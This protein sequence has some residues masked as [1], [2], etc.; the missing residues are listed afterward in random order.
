[1]AITRQELDGSPEISFEGTAIKVTC[2]YMI[3]WSSVL[4]F[5]L[6]ILADGGEDSYHVPDMRV[7]ARRIP[8]VEG[9][10]HIDRGAPPPSGSAE[11]ECAIVTV[12]YANY[13]ADSRDRQVDEVTKETFSEQ[14]LPTTE[15]LTVA[16]EDANQ[17]ALFSWTGVGGAPISS[18]QA[19]GMLV[20]SFDYLLTYFDKRDFDDRILTEYPGTVNMY[21]L[22]TRWGLWF[23]PETLLFHLPS[24]ERG[25]TATGTEG[26]RITYQ[27][28]Y[29]KDTWNKF[30]NPK[31]NAWLPLWN[32]S[33]GVVQQFYKP[34]L[35]RH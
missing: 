34:M 19:P 25:F 8:R 29:R 9:F 4:S 6:E 22:S 28:S 15:F 18:D 7:V 32:I 20:K 16:T 31:E 1:M 30:Y 17:Q 11:Y 35:W 24:L 14:I 27:Y 21:A 3:A 12:E 23:A 26:W 5:C 2:R 13:D 10:G 33:K